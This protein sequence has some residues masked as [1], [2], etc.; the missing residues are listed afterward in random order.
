MSRRNTNKKI[1]R[2]MKG[3][4]IWT[5]F[6]NN[7]EK[8]NK[9][10]KMSHCH[11]ESIECVKEEQMNCINAAFYWDTTPEGLEFWMLQSIALKKYLK[12]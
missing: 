11:N 2:W 1:I 12:R 8:D 7:N 3:R 6:C 5:R 9:F 4:G 10:H